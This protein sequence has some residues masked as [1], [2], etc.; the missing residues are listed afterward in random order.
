MRSALFAPRRRGYITQLVEALTRPA[1]ST[2]D[3]ALEIELEN[4]LGMEIDLALHEAPSAID[5]PKSDVVMHLG[6]Q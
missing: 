6:R 2:T 3:E 1:D 5:A 4:Q